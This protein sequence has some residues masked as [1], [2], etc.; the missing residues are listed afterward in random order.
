MHLTLINPPFTFLRRDDIVFPQCLG[1]LYLASVARM[2]GHQVTV[3][4][5]LRQGSNSS[6]R[7]PDGSI[8][9]GLSNRQT[10]S[11]IPTGTDVIG[12]SAPF[13]HSAPVVHQL[14]SDIKRAFSKV[15]LILGGVYPSTQ[16]GLAITSEAD[17]LILGE[18]QHS[19]VE[20]LDYLAR[21]AG[22]LPQGVVSSAQP[23]SLAH[24][25]PR[26]VEDLSDLPPPARDL[27]PFEDYLGRSTRNLPGWRTAT[28]ITSLGCPFRCEF[29]SIHPVNGYTWRVRPPQSVLAEIEGLGRDYRVNNLEIED[30]NFTL[31]RTHAVEI[32][33][34]IIDINRRGRKLAWRAPNGLRIDT[35]DEELIRLIRQSNCLDICLALEHGDEDMLA[36]MN[37][38]LSLTRVLEVMSLVHK[39]RIRSKIFVI[40]GYPGETKERFARALS[41]YRE[42]KRVA[43]GAS[44]RPFFAQPYPGTQLFE[45]C[46]REGYLSRDSFNSLEG[47]TRLFCTADTV[48]LE[49]PDFTRQEV[50][51]RRQVLLWSLA[52]EL[53]Y[54]EMLRQVVPRKLIDV[55]RTWHVGNGARAKRSDSVPPRVEAR[56]NTQT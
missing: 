53:Y 19:L 9:V 15:P 5:A 41:F 32:L 56:A 37:K 12:L 13:S 3:V 18:G 21:H 39:Y 1:I 52:P 38:K 25:K 14:T 54:Y 31:N 40:C 49:T 28:I 34:G 26:F 27:L 30:D 11:R 35:L 36:S 29:C 2:H 51:A 22:P 10:I 23:E 6:V 16:P 24:A 7:M 20:L 42:V 4:D 45:R 50:K 44:F 33:K 48:W 17:Y 47:L 43:P 46:V 55:T 8:K